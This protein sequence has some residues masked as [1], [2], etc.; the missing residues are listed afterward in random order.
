MKKLL[1]ILALLLPMLVL[2]A[3]AGNCVF[4]G[5]YYL[6]PTV[7]GVDS[8]VVFRNLADAD[9]YIEYTGQGS[10]EWRDFAGVQQASGVGDYYPQ[11]GGVVLY[12]NGKKRAAYYVLDYRQL[13]L[14]TGA[15]LLAEVACEKTQLTLDGMLPTAAYVDTT[16]AKHV[17]KREHHLAYTNLGWTG[18]M[19][20]DSAVVDTIVLR[21]DVATQ[22]VMADPLLRDSAS[23]SLRLDAGWFP[24]PD[25]VYSNP[26]WGIAVATRPAYVVTARGDRQ[27]NEPM[28]PIGK[29]ELS[30]T[31]P[32][33]APVEVNFLSNANRPTQQ[34]YRWRIM[35]GSDLIAERFDQ[36]QRFTFTTNGLY[37]VFLWAYNDQCTTDS[38]V[39]EVSVNSSQLKVPNVFTPN[40]DG[41][42]D[43]F[44]VVYTSLSEFHCWIYNRWGK[45]VYQWDDPAKG[46]DGTINGHPAAEG[47][48]Y[49]VIRAKGTDAKQ[50]DDYHKVTKRKP[51]DI[52]VYQLSGHV[53]IIRGK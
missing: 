33:S 43:E 18:T 28:R 6:L 16:G 37:Q 50:G 20:A 5:K 48:Y 13:A 19:W 30:A 7:Q 47:A 2:P 9:A 12:V 14:A 35:K 17:V 25:S 49:Y 24:E 51:M 36:D 21:T 29:P 26:V 39:F 32:L 53:N 11:E 3:S 31:I 1:Y 38:A 22:V 8:V 34:F 45:L 41:M 40:G 42:N 44:R 15:T 4:H 10:A 52:G 46:W 27:E 23:Y